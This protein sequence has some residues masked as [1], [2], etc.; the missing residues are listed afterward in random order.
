MYASSDYNAQMFI[1][2]YKFV[3]FSVPCI[4]VHSVNEESADYCAS[5][6]CYN[7]ATCVNRVK[8]FTCLCADQ[9]TGRLCDKSKTG[10]KFVR[11]E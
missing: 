9:F 4:Y 7:G 3:C 8:D 6:T 2:F 10:L 1:H 5:S 11:A